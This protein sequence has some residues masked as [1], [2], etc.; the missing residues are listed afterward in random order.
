MY[1]LTASCRGPGQAMV[2]RHCSSIYK[3]DESKWPSLAKVWNSSHLAEE[4][5]SIASQMRRCH[6]LQDCNSEELLEACSRL[7]VLSEKIRDLERK[8]MV[9]DALRDAEQLEQKSIDAL[10][11]LKSY[12]DGG[13]R[14]MCHEILEER[15][16]ESRVKEH[17]KDLKT[18]FPDA[19]IIQATTS[20]TETVEAVRKQ[21]H[22]IFIIVPPQNR[23]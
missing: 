13:S 3:K 4:L 20:L 8:A 10:L 6:L 2:L 16:F 22:P 7:V 1:A 11:V 23:P 5:K 14:D 21:T 9:F 18:Q 19:E 17:I 15:N 12:A